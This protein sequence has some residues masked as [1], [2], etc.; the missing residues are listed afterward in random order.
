MTTP[1]LPALMRHGILL[2][3]QAAG[4]LSPETSAAFPLLFGACAGTCP[5]PG[6]TS[7]FLEQIWKLQQRRS[8]AR[9]HVR[10][11]PVAR[12][13]AVADAASQN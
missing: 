9:C 4:A 8:V 11:S 6:V 1:D 3:L 2:Y 12:Y 13:Y 7:L 10:G 5:A